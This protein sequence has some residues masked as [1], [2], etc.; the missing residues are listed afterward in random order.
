MQCGSQM[1]SQIA[2]FTE[3]NLQIEDQSARRLK[4]A[5]KTRKLGSTPRALQITP[6]VYRFNGR[7]SDFRKRIWVSGCDVSAGTLSLRFADVGDRDDDDATFVFRSFIAG[8]YSI[9][10]ICF[11]SA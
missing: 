6:H 1:L 11:A 3:L 7:H 4:A 5:N 8:D 2:A 10:F 9:F